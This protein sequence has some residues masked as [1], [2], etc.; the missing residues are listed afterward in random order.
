MLQEIRFCFFFSLQYH[1][2]I[3][4]KC[5]FLCSLRHRSVLSS[6]FKVVDVLI[7]GKRNAVVRSIA[8]ARTTESSRST[9]TAA[10]PH[11]GPE[12]DGP[13]TLHRSLLARILPVSLRRIEHHLL[14]YVCRVHLK[15]LT[16]VYI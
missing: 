9:G 10:R 3:E 12:A 6:G 2:I 8:E 7:A 15:Q 1:D 11:T 14:G 4:L 16:I 5:F 13:R